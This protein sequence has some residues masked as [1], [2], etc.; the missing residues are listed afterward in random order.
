[1]YSVVINIH[2]MTTITLAHA[3]RVIINERDV[4]FSLIIINSYKST[5]II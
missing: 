4:V 5:A 2:R 1:M 3:L